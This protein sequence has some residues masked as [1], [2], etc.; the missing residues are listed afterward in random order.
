MSPENLEKIGENMQK[1]EQLT[2][3][4]VTVISKRSA[5]HPALNGPDPEVFTKAMG[6]YWSEMMQNPARIFEHQAEF[7][8]KS[9][10]HYLE[11]QQAAQQGT[12]AAPEDRTPDDPRFDNPLWKTNPYFNFVKQQYMLN[13]EAVKKAVDD[14]EGLDEIERRRLKYFSQQIV[15]MMAPTNFLATNPDA[16]EKAAKTEGQSLVDGLENLVSDIEA[17]NG[18]IHVIDA[19]LMPE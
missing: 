10:K 19:V 2:Q 3:R 17:S 13:A 12:L 4:L 15:D 1:L 14:A 6:A 16:L 9:V 11:A 8:A 18:V 7:W 5:T